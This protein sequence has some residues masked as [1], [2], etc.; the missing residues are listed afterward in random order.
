MRTLT[1]FLCLLCAGLLAAMPARAQEE[2]KLTFNESLESDGRLVIETHKGSITVTTWDRDEVAVE[3]RIVADETDALVESTDVEVRRSGGTLRFE[4]Q[5]D[6]DV[7]K[8]LRRRGLLDMIS[9]GFSQPF[10]HYEIR[11]PRTARLEIDDYKSEISVRGLQADLVIDTYKGEVEVEDLDGALR[12][13]TY[14]GTGHIVFSRLAESSYVETYKGDVTLVLPR[15][16][17]FD[18]DADLGRRGKLRSDFDVDNRRR[19][20]DDDDGYWDAD[21][22]DNIVR[23]AVNGGGPRLRLES[24]KGRIALRRVR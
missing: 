9:N 21:D 8:R 18:L 7:W 13:D 24:Y 12:F 23:G 10:V 6:E 17:G 22:D 2:K 14:K 16:A 15:N 3:V 5:Y 1:V 4:T 19:R 11:M 20:D